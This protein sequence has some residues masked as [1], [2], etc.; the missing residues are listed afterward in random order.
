MCSFL[1]SGN[2]KHSMPTQPSV[3]K[4][5]INKNKTVNA[6]IEKELKCFINFLLLTSLS[7]RPLHLGIIIF[8]MYTIRQSLEIM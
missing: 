8:Q 1:Y 4:V 7:I 5:N 2:I 3:S 6:Y